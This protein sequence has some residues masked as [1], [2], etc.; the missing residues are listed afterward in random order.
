MIF[1]AAAG[2]DRRIFQRRTRTPP[3]EFPFGLT[4]KF[5]LSRRPV[6]CLVFGIGAE[7]NGFDPRR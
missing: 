2:G 7:E 6:V 1:D 3:A 4:P 5:L